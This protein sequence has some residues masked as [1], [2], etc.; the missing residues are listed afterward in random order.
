VVSGVDSFTNGREK[1]AYT[2]E[3]D[4]QLLSIVLKESLPSHNSVTN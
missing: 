2:P 3:V 4:F 1:V